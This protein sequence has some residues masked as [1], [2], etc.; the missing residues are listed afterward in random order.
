MAATPDAATF[1]SGDGGMVPVGL[2]PVN[3]E[4]VPMAFSSLRVLS[5]VLLCA[6]LSVSLRAAMLRKFLLFKEESGCDA[7]VFLRFGFEAG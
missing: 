3:T 6:A 7:G 4:G 2:G 1:G 5:A